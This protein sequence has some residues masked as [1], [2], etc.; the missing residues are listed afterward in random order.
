[1]NKAENRIPYKFGSRESR[2]SVVTTIT[3]EAEL[4]CKPG[5]FD[6]GLDTGIVLATTLCNY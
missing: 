6:F 4:M 3:C 2:R 1:M 5:V